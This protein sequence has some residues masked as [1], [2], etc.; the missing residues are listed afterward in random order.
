[1]EPALR[2]VRRAFDCGLAHHTGGSRRV[3]GRVDG[4]VVRAAGAGAEV[5]PCGGAMWQ[6]EHIGVFSTSMRARK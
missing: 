3:F 5:V 2:L 6:S 4:D 1:M